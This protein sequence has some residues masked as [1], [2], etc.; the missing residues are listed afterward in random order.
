MAQTVT[1]T[2]AVEAVDRI[3]IES[4][5]WAE[6]RA[7]VNKHGLTPQLRLASERLRAL[8]QMS[9]EGVE[10]LLLVLHHTDAGPRQPKL[11][12]NNGELVLMSPFSVIGC[13]FLQ[14][15]R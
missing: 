4:P 15:S 8:E 1:V 11:H 5:H 9:P 7:E 14:F 10:R 3:E 2:A 13:E 6:W 12:N